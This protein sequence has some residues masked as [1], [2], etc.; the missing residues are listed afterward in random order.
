MAVF[1]TYAQYYD[2]IYRG[3]DYAGEAEFV[4]RQLAAQGTTPRSLLDLGCGTGRHAAQFAAR[5]A[6]VVGVDMSE[7]MVELGRSEIAALN[8]LANPPRLAIG[9]ARTTRLGRSFDAVVS[10]FHVA[11]Y[12]TSEDDLEAYFA[13]AAAHLAPGGL[14]LFDFW[15]GPGVLVTPPEDREKHLEDGRIIVDRSARP[16]HDLTRHQVD[17][18]YDVR[19]TDK[20]SGETSAFSETHR[21]RYWFLPEIAYIARRAGLSVVTAAAWMETRPATRDDWTAWVVLRR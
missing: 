8:G 18:N 4:L 5:G 9:D 15:H 17:V 12:Q 7:M 10:L 14:F 19:V 2:L 20:R 6:E 13:T 21:M 1:A 11:S 3:K 16:V